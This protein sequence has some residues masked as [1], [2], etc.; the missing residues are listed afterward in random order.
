MSTLELQSA[1]DHGEPDLSGA[2][3]LGETVMNMMMQMY[4]RAKK[5]FFFPTT[6]ATKEV[7]TVE[8]IAGG[9]KVVLKI[10]VGRSARHGMEEVCCRINATPTIG[11]DGTNFEQEF[12]THSLALFSDMTVKSDKDGIYYVW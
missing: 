2:P 1:V 3:V 11:W 4:H 12:L 9:T 6:L 7:K 8:G 5:E 10:W